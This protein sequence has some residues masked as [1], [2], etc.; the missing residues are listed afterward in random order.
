MK[1]VETDAYDFARERSNLQILTAYFN[2]DQAPD[3]EAFIRT[4]PADA[5]IRIVGHSYGG[6]T[7]AK[8][9]ANS[10]RKI[11]LLVT[12]DPVSRGTPNFEKVRANTVRWINLYADWSDNG[13]LK[14]LGNGASWIGGQWKTDVKP[15]VGD[16][17]LIM[18]ANREEYSRLMTT[19]QAAL[20]GRSVRHVVADP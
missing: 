18:K 17:F 8:I 14:S 10:G 3:I 19:P 5:R 9:V 15:V 20:R 1:S 7:A 16:D 12:V 6:D 11:E 2:Q 13:L 4:L